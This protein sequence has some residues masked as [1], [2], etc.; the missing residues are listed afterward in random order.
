MGEYVPE[1]T[2]FIHPIT[3][4]PW[5]AQKWSHRA[6]TMQHHS[7]LA[8]HPDLDKLA[9]MDTILGNSDRHFGNVLV[10]PNKKLQLI[11]N[12]G[13]FDYGHVFQAPN[14]AYAKHLFSSN[15]S[16]SASKWLKGITPSHFEAM[17]KENKV[18]ESLINV[19]M[20][21]LHEGKRWL[22]HANGNNQFNQSLGGLLAVIK[23]HRIANDDDQL[24]LSKMR[25]SYYNDMHR[26]KIVDPAPIGANDKTV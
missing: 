26:G 19:A 21:R 2:T 20:A 8:H 15:V 7:E 17:L 5:S 3:K 4:Q 22:R 9:I 25:N 24:L 6:S 16:S 1:T 14:P 18:P 23:T 10:T 11:D 12:A 13:S